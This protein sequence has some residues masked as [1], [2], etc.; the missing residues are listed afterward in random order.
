V[1]QR[2]KLGPA[3]ERSVTRSSSAA[4]IRPAISRAHRKSVTPR[5]ARCVPLLRPSALGGGATDFRHHTA[6]AA[7][8]AAQ[9]T[10][11]NAY[12]HLT[13][14]EVVAQGTRQREQLMAQFVSRVRVRGEHEPHRG[15]FAPWLG[16]TALHI[17]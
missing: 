6:H 9:A 11:A 12:T 5:S 3:E 2:V 10:E 16:A 15:A 1:T 7:S 4:A 14:A 8:L 17:A 13:A